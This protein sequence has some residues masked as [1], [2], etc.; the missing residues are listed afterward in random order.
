MSFKDRV[1]SKYKIAAAVK[2]ISL[3]EAKKRGMFGPVYHGTDA[4][5]RAKIEQEGFKVFI[6][7]ERSGDISHG[8]QASSYCEGKPAPIHHLGFGA[9][10][11]TSKNVAKQ[12]NRNSLKGLKAYYL[13]VPR[14]ETINFGANTTMMKWWSKNGYDIVPIYG[15]DKQ[16]STEEIAKMRLDATNRLTDKLKESFDAVWFKG[17]GLYRLLDGDQICVFDPARIYETDLSLATGWEAGSKVRRKSDGMAGVIQDVRDATKMR[18]EFPGCRTWVKEETT[19]ML[20]V[21]WKK[22][23]TD[24]NVQDVDVEL[25]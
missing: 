10:F 3:A 5:N 7:H 12:Y 22:G 15:Q 8:Y 4:E 14:L 25:S 20:D 6:G 17:R 2:K 11:T 9:Y 1:T 21:K 24:R 19:K 18:E 16:Y 23:G 13:D